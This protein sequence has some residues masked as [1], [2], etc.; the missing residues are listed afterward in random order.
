MTRFSYGWIAIGLLA[1]IGCQAP[2]GAVAGGAM[3][4]HLTTT[5]AD[6]EVVSGP[7][8]GASGG[9]PG[10]GTGPAGDDPLTI[11]GPAFPGLGLQTHTAA[12][13]PFDDVYGA[14]L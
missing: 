12:C 2:N 10:P 13:D 6:Q 9:A 14:C 7:R 1:L 4:S 11:I 3:E 5:T 8:T